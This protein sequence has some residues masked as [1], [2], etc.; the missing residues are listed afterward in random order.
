M[1][2]RLLMM[3]SAVFMAIIGLAATFLPQEMAVYFGADRGGF[4][5]IA[6]Q[7]LGALYL[8]FAFL[9]W[10]ARG[11]L[12][13]GIYGRAVTLGNLCHFTVGALA[14]VKVL[15]RKQGTVELAILAAAYAF[16]VCPDP[17][18]AGAEVAG[19][20][21]RRRA[22]RLGPARLRIPIHIP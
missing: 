6:L 5:A 12:I 18:Y 9:N 17:V 21:S 11:H 2:A 4:A 15:W 14:L 22:A 19:N 13:G 20:G 7:V 3:L 8:G 10:T 16:V 1:K